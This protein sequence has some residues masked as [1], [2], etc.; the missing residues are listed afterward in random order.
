G[1]V[2][3]RAAAARSCGLIAALLIAWPAGS[4]ALSTFQGTVTDQQSGEPIVGAQVELFA[5]QSFASG[6]TIDTTITDA[7]GHFHVVNDGSVSFT[8]LSLS[9]S[10]PDYQS[11]GT[12]VTTAT[13]GHTQD[14]Q[15]WR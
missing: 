8:Y 1:Q 5:V 14:I 9:A 11:D 10:H 2:R 7:S 12:Y 6:Q 15:L 13:G 4:Q 3:G